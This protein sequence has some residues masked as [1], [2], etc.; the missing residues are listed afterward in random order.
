MRA[1]RLSAGSAAGLVLLWMTGASAQQAPAPVTYFPPPDSWERRDPASVGM[2]A[3]RLAS[4][5]EWART[6]ESSYDFDKFA[7]A[8]KL[9]GEVPAGRTAVNGLVIRHG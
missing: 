9:L 8:G 5:V 7:A 4:A 1:L 2:N 3:D 6:H